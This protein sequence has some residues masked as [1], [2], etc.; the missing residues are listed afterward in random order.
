M[1]PV[2][3]GED[4]TPVLAER[5]LPAGNYLVN[6][7]T[8]VVASAAPLTVSCGIF[9]PGGIRSD[10]S[11]ATLENVNSEASIPLQAT[12]TLASGSTV[13]LDCSASTGHGGD[14]SA[15]FSQL[16]LTKVGL[17]N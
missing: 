1:S 8:S 13:T 12:I 9:L 6:A 11:D 5:N 7:K 16:N 14:V 4:F 17:I 2:R 3:L 15:Q 10:E